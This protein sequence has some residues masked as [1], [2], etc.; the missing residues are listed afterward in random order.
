MIKKNE[1]PSA[2]RLS[3]PFLLPVNLGLVPNYVVQPPK[4]LATLFTPSADRGQV[5]L[6]SPLLVMI[7]YVPELFFLLL[8][9]TPTAILFGTFSV[10]FQVS[11]LMVQRGTDSL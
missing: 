7:P 3:I 9:L 5:L 4:L 1:T 10:L 11:T 8:S 2:S 6:L